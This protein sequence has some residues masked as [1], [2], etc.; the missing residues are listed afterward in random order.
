MTLL[1]MFCLVL[2]TGCGAK[3]SP[4]LVSMEQGNIADVKRLMAGRE[5]INSVIDGTSW[6]S[7]MTPLHK[8]SEAGRPDIVR[9]LIDAGADVNSTS[10][11]SGYTP[12]HLAAEE[13]HPDIVRVLIDAG[14]DVHSTKRDTGITPL[15]KAA[16]SG[17]L[18]IVK[19]L[20]RQG[21]L[22]KMDRSQKETLLSYA[23]NGVASD[24]RLEIVRLLLKKG[25]SVKAVKDRSIVL[26]NAIEYNGEEHPNAE[27][28]IRILLKAGAD[29]NKGPITF[30]S[31][32]AMAVEKGNRNIVELLL[33]NGAKVTDE[34]VRLF[35]SRRGDKRKTGIIP[36]FVKY[37][38]IVTPADVERVFHSDLLTDDKNRERDRVIMREIITGLSKNKAVNLLLFYMGDPKDEKDIARQLRGVNKDKK[39]RIYAKYGG[40]PE[41]GNFVVGNR[42][43]AYVVPLLDGYVR[44]DHETKYNSVT[45]P[46]R[47]VIRKENDEKYTEHQTTMGCSGENGGS[48]DGSRLIID[49][50]YITVRVDTDYDSMECHSFI[51]YNGHDINFI[52]WFFPDENR[53][54]YLIVLQ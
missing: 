12:L 27:E 8:A 11:N 32:L 6:G 42:S 25:V 14:A 15:H 51:S 40:G 48:I 4:L 26:V 10:H 2:N 29:V 53:M 20:I 49:E 31:P 43:E 16:D 17:H 39:L 7:N 9:F 54:D 50:K 5:D 18:E 38:Y 52:Q 21:A 1:S 23:V 41:N 13:G 36:L 24:E 33:K 28:L 35:L 34:S 3:T 44:L 30:R 46:Y 19:L 37:G 22:N 45:F 47:H